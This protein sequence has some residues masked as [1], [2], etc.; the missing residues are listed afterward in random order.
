MHPLPVDAILG[1]LVAALGDRG[2]AVLVAPPGSGK[3]TRA[4]PALAAAFSGRICLLQPRRVAA[5]LAARRMAAERGTRVGQEVGYRIRF[6]NRTSAKTKIEVLTEGLLTRMMQGDPF[7]EGVGA[8]VF[9]EFHERSLHADLALALAV[10]IQ[11]DARPDLKILVMSATLD[12]GPLASFLGDCPVIRAEGRAFPVDLV[13]AAAPDDR[14]IEIRAAEAIRGALGRTDTGHVLVFLPGVGEIERTRERLRGLDIPVLPLHGRLDGA[15]QDRA[16]APSD[17]RKV[18]LATNIAETSVT[19]AGATVVVDAGLHRQ[20]RFLPKLGATR[21][22][23]Q[24]ISGA[25]A[26]Q[27]AGRAGRTGPGVCVRLWTVSTPRIP[28]EVPEI[29]RADLAPALLQVFAWG[30]DPETFGWFDRPPQGLLRQGLGLLEL[31]DAVRDGQITSTGRDMARLPLHPRLARVVLE[32]VARGCAKE[33]ATAAAL[34]EERDPWPDQQPELMERIAWVDGGAGGDPRVLSAIRRARDQILG[35]SPGGSGGSEVDVVR[36]LLAG[37]PDRVARRRES[38]GKRYLLAS[39]QGA[40]LSGRLRPSEWLLALDLAAGRRGLEIRQA[41]P[42]DPSWLQVVTRDQVRFEAK[43]QR[44]LVERVEAFG[45]LVLSSRPGNS[46][47]GQVSSVLAAAAARSVRKALSFT[48]DVDRFLVRLR[49]LADARPGLGLPTFEDWGPLLE[50][51]CMG[52]S[53][54]SGLRKRDLLS[55]LRGFMGFEKARSLDRLAPKAWPIPSGSRV[56]IVYGDPGSPPVL[57]ARIQQLFGMRASPEIAGIRVA[58][59]LLAPNNRPQQITADL[60]SFWST[61]YAQVRK[62]LRGR[63]PKHP[64]PEDPLT[65]VATDRAKRRK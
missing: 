32:G 11:K 15:A 59:H 28:F 1:D 8:L 40:Q 34:V 60:E 13:H 39:G 41:E 25:S 3:T 37:F 44:V 61:T 30:E 42:L 46:D 31:L 43:E 48:R 26:T 57:A 14:R 6:E 22:E 65:A 38:D 63:Y 18:V 52:E 54:F 33:A 16:L 7:L 2:A 5:R 19:L 51:L 64:W 20:P 27:R 4:P 50:S 36:S 58:V 53:S 29:H 17:E 21:L 62:D 45:A 47:P 55:E 56:P 24:P 49:W 9:D 12:A 10:E 23:L 35:R